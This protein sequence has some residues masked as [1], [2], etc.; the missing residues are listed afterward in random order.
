MSERLTVRWDDPRIEAMA[1]RGMEEEGFDNLS[2]YVRSAIVRDRFLSG[3]KD[4]RKMAGENVLKWWRQKGY[5][6]KIR[7]VL[8]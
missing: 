6:K 4:A 1:M 5:A 2:D 3:D 8:D 7:L